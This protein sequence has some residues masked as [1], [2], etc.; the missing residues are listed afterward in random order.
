M[1]TYVYSLVW[2]ALHVVPPDKLPAGAPEEWHPV[3]GPDDVAGLPCEGVG[4]PGVGVV[5]AAG[6]VEQL[7]VLFRPGQLLAP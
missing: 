7:L 4:E 1:D 6:E 5:G 3:Y 2:L